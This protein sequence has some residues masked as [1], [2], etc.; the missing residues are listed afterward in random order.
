MGDAWSGETDYDRNQG[1][2]DAER[3]AEAAAR[4]AATQKGVDDYASGASQ[5]TI[6]LS[7]TQEEQDS[8]LGA[9]NTAAT[10]YGQN[11]GQTG[12]DIQRV[13]ELQSQRTDQSGKDPVSAA[14]MGQKAGAQANAQRSLASSGVKGGAA[15]GAVDAIGRSRDADI[16]ASLYGQQRQSISDE[17]SLASNMLSGSVGMMQAGKGEGTAAGMPSAPKASGLM[18]S[19]ICTELYSQ[20]IMPLETYMRDAAYGVRLKLH[21]PHVVEGYHFWA[22]PLV[23]IMQKSP[24]VTKLL[25]YPTMKWARHIAGEEFSVFGVLCQYLGEP[26]CGVIG[27][28]ISNPT[29]AKYV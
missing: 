17:R 12:Q 5:G 16:A 9:M 18:D 2:R 15:A 7:G 3:A 11:I 14:I 21:K 8:Q 1:K 6:T 25:Q 20:G 24:L 27:K 26:I 4:R 28:L 29:G 19:V 22:K 13:K 10:G 23:K